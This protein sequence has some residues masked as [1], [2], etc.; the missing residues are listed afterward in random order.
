M[1]RPVFDFG[2]P[3][4]P[5]ARQAD[6]LYDGFTQTA[7]GFDQIWDAYAV[8]GILLPFPN[9]G[10]SP[11]QPGT[12]GYGTVTVNQYGQVIAATSKEAPVELN[13]VDFGA[14]FDGAS[15]IGPALMA[16][17]SALGPRGGIIQC[18][19]GAGRIETPVIFSGKPVILRG[20]GMANASSQG[21]ALTLA[22][23]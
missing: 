14:V 5:N 18:P 9:I 1:V 2:V 17:Y 19:P 16:A 23:P 7:L 22:Q 15:D 21:T 12:Y 20:A 11:V 10:L 3:A 8:D 6:D 4:G 13:P